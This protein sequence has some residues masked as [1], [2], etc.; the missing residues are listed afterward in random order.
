MGGSQDGRIIDESALRRLVLQYA[1]AVDRNDP[2]LFAS[3]F[4]EDAVVE[5]PGFRFDGRAAARSARA[6]G[7]G[8]RD[9][10]HCVF[11]HS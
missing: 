11:N 6:T 10:M 4:V 8:F 5:G 2:E 1:S 3:I 9:T 7:A